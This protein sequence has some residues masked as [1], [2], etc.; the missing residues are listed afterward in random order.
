MKK[1]QRGNKGVLWVVP[2]GREG[3]FSVSPV[4]YLCFLVLLSVCECPCARIV[5]KSISI[6]KQKMMELSQDAKLV[7]FQ[8]LQRRDQLRVRAVCQQFQRLI[9]E[10]AAKEW[11]LRMKGDEGQSGVL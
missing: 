10:H 1:R 6:F 11:K 5:A 2:G 9:D 8:F 3:F 7:I 4:S